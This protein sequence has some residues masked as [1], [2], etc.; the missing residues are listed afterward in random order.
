M[1]SRYKNKD[2]SLNKNILFNKKLILASASPR[3]IDLLRQIAIEPDIIEP[4]D[5]DET[6]LKNE[7]PTVYVKRVAEEKALAVAKRYPDSFILAADTVVACSRRI[8]TKAET[9]EDAL[10]F[11]TMLSGRRHRVH[12]GVCL[13]KPD[14]KIIIRRVSTVVTFKRLSEQEIKEYILSEEW[15]GKA[16]GYAIQGRAAAFVKKINGSYSNVV[17]LPLHETKNM[18]CG[19]V[20]T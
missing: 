13:L 12:G 17:G 14:G 2:I 20:N 15:H 6:P 19:A 5:I 11:L 16:G 1:F 4:A 9:K 3:R 18:L 8:L 10:R 7:T